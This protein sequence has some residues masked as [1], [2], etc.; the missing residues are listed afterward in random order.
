MTA[1][2]Q[3][4]VERATRFDLR[5]R[6]PYQIDLEGERLTVPVL[7][8]EFGPPRGMLLVA[9]Y[10]EIDAFTKRVV[11]AG[12][13]YSCLGE[14]TEEDIDESSIIDM[15]RDWGWSGSREAPSWYAA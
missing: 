7:L 12:Y 8:E 1:F 5:V 4:W 15:L 3:R 11:A 9:S 6:I 14:P 13:G 10:G 2:Q